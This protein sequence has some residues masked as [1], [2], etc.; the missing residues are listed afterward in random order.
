MIILKDQNWLTPSE[1]A[2]MLNI[3]PFAVQQMRNRGTIPSEIID[4]KRYYSQT[5]V[6]SYYPSRRKLPKFNDLP[7]DQQN[8]IFISLQQAANVLH[9]SPSQIRVRLSKGI[10]TGYCTTDGIIMVSK[11]SMENLMG[12]SYDQLTNI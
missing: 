8:D 6:E 5:E 7:Q 10:L 9:Y 2:E 1:A 12:V 4:G 11:T 3:T